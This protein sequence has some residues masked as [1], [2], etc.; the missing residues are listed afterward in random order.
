[1]TVQIGDTIRLLLLV[2][3]PNQQQYKVEAFQVCDGQ[4]PVDDHTATHSSRY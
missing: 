4:L 3:F 2:Y 1:M